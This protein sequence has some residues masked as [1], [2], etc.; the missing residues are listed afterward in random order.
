MNNIKFDS[1]VIN[2]NTSN[3]VS[4]WQVENIKYLINIYLF[5]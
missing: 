4:N 5:I 3:C 2:I 1:D